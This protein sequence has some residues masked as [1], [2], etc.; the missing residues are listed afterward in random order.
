MKI[1]YSILVWLPPEAH[2]EKR[3]QEQEV[4]WEGSPGKTEAWGEGN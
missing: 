4:Y 1:V 2:S 3:I